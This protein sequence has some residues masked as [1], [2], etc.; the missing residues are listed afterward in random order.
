MHSAFSIR[1]AKAEENV[2]SGVVG[3]L[4]IYLPLPDVLKAIAILF[5]C[6]H[7]VLRMIMEFDFV[8]KDHTPYLPYYIRFK[9][10]S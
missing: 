9:F 3:Y 6:F 7:L 5:S 1:K 8:K 10:I 4:F 2:I